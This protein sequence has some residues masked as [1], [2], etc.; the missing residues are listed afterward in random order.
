MTIWRNGTFQFNF[1]AKHADCLN[2]DVRKEKS[3][4]SL[5]EQDVLI[6]YFRH[7]PDSFY[8]LDKCYNYR[9]TLLATKKCGEC[10][11]GICDERIKVLHI[12]KLLKVRELSQT[13]HTAQRL[14]T[15]LEAL[16]VAR[17]LLTHLPTSQHCWARTVDGHVCVANTLVARYV[18]CSEYSVERRGTARN[19]LRAEA[20]VSYPQ[21]VHLLPVPT[22]PLR[23][24]AAQLPAAKV[25]LRCIH[26]EHVWSVWV[27]A[28]GHPTTHRLG[29]Q[30]HPV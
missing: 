19:R 8:N 30:Q 6:E 28:L 13:T 18:S 2:G 25:I 22:Y 23:K 4:T 3:R 20:R 5:T 17:A 15:L 16:R 9:G 24:L 29:L 27:T 26:G 21:P 10:Q 7:H 12:A 1:G 14:R 11:N